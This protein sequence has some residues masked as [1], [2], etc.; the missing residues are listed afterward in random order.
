MN[1]KDLGD[2]FKLNLKFIEP[3]TYLTLNGKTTLLNYDE[4]ENLE[5]GL[6]NLAHAIS[7]YKQSEFDCKHCN[8]LRDVI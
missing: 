3:L 4:L 1:L 5:Y 7:L 8:S 6:T 2:N